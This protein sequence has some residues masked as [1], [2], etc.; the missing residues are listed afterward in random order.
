[1]GIVNSKNSP[2]NIDK[3][4]WKNPLPYLEFLEKL[5]SKQLYNISKISAQ[6]S[7]KLLKDVLKEDIKILGGLKGQLKDRGSGKSMKSPR[8]NSMA[9]PKNK[10]KSS[11]TRKIKKE[12][13]T[14]TN[15]NINNRLKSLGLTLENL[16]YIGI[17]KS[18]FEKMS[19]DEFLN[20][21]QT[22]KNESENEEQDNNSLG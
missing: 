15:T 19:D 12:H 8:N 1:M 3:F 7:N 16:E 4:D 11:S 17:S 10:N 18:D 14:N 5:R 22:L 21:I 13:N 6:T 20:I 9:S 2:Y